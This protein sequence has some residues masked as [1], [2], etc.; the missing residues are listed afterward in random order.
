MGHTQY[1]YIID[2]AT[3]GE[4]QLLNAVRLGV[5]RDNYRRNAATNGIFLCPT[6]HAFFTALN[7]VVLSL[8]IPILKY[9]LTYVSTTSKAKWKPLH[10]VFEL[11]VDI[12]LEDQ[13]A[14]ELPGN[15][16]PILPYIGLFT[17]V[18]LKPDAVRNDR[19]LTPYLPTLSIIEDSTFVEAPVHTP[20]TAEN[21]AR[22]F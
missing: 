20:A 16:E 19:I 17:L 10:K 22:I 9:L 4:Q 8:P 13:G 11:L 18:T 3:A 7:E 1:T 2:A 5:L 14:E 6:C 12:S 21:V 15:V